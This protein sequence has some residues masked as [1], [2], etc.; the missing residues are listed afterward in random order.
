LADEP[1]GYRESHE[2]QDPE[3]DP[4][5]G[6]AASGE[7]G[8]CTTQTKRAEYDSDNAEEEAERRLYEYREEAKQP[9]NE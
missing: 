4:R 1:R 6:G 9:A 2:Q 8:S 3:R 5:D 7:S